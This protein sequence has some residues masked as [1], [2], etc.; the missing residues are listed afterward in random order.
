MSTT[1]AANLSA[2][3]AESDSE[4]RG[5]LAENF[6]RDEAC[7]LN[8]VMRFLLSNMMLNFLTRPDFVAYNF[9]DRNDLAPGLCRKLWSPQF[10]WWVIKSQ[11]RANQV[12][13]QG[14]LIIFE[15]FPAK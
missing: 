10:F 5:Q 3:P 1:G 7:T 8:P 12:I 4:V 14:D 6:F 2:K 9:E 13:D 15:G 11:E